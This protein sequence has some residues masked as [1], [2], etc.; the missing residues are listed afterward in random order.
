MR[1]GHN[2]LSL[3]ACILEQSAFLLAYAG[4]LLSRLLA[5]PSKRHLGLGLGGGECSLGLLASLRQSALSLLV[6]LFAQLLGCPHSLLRVH[7]DRSYRCKRLVSRLLGLS[8]CMRKDL[9]GLLLGCFYAVCGGTIGLRDALGSPLLSLLA[10]LACRS[11]GSL[12]D[13]PHSR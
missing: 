11:L 5:C 12:D 10:Q 8:S 3:L 2:R 9:A 6:C 13:A 1:L 7:M 4:Q